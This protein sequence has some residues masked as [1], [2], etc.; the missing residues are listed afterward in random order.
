MHDASGDGWADLP[1]YDRLVVRPRVFWSDGAGRSLFVTLGGTAEARKGGT[2]PG[3]TTPAGAPYQET[4]ETR[5]A[6]VGL[7][8]RSLLGETR[9]VTVRASVMAQRHDHRFGE[10]LERD[11]HATEFAEATLAGSRHGHTWLLGAGIEHEE[12]AS[13]DVPRFDF[14]H[15][16]P[17]MFAQTEISPA[18]WATIAASGRVDRHGEYGTILS[19]RVSVLVL[20]ADEWNVRA[21]VGTG[22][23]APTPFTEETEVLGLT[24]LEPLRGLRLERARSGSLDVGRTLGHF[25][26]NGTLF[27]SEIRDPLIVRRFGDGRIELVNAAGPTR[28]Y[29]T[30]LLLRTHEEPFHL[31][32]AYTYTRSREQDPTTGSRR[33]VPMTPR[34]AAG[35]VGMWEAEG[36][37][38]AGVELYA[39][40]RQEVDENPYR[41]MTPPYLVIG[42]FGERRVGRARPFVNVENLLDR[43]QTRHDPLLLPARSPEGR[44]TTDVWA[45]LEGRTFNAGVR[46]EF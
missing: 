17:S 12:Y 8:G 16:T 25:E 36:S 31:T 3:R 40:G 42:V 45:P 2:L 35:L 24:R 5:K 10:T 33:E 23:F 20:P 19:P 32:V 29:G 37:G 41:S 21:S 22:Y 39:T 34:H 1:E 27:G 15:L 9:L 11:R 14:A 6:T 4:L 46:V 38:R 43:R 26:L 7:V 44:W 30:D 13:R 28:T 18:S